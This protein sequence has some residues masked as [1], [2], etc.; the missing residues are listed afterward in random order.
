MERYEIFR[1]TNKENIQHPEIL[2]LLEEKDLVEHQLYFD[3]SIGDLLLYVYDNQEKQIVGY[4]SLDLFKEPLTAL[5]IAKIE[6]FDE[7]VYG[8]NNR[9]KGVASMLLNYITDYARNND[10]E[11]IQLAAINKR[12]ENLYYQHGFVTYGKHDL[13]WAKME[14]ESNPTFWRLSC[15]LFE[16]MREARQNNTNVKT[17]VN[18]ILKNR[19]YDR[20]FEYNV[21]EENPFDE[22]YDPHLTFFKFD[23]LMREDCEKFIH[24]GVHERVFKTLDN[25]IK[26]SDQDFKY[27]IHKLAITTSTEHSVTVPYETLF[28]DRICR[29]VVNLFIDDSLNSKDTIEETSLRKD[30]ITNTTK[31]SKINNDT[32]S[33]KSYEALNM[34]LPK[35]QALSEKGHNND[36]TKGK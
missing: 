36:F 5:Y 11:C 27:K 12:A 29:N 31:T 14:K 4:A 16:G 34:F 2:K 33:N 20:L 3:I 32:K 26:G 35:E 30:E 10:Y 13:G 24:S 19:E 22:N 18:K 9:N 23:K 15:L 6:T 25:V 21:I 7:S 1:A 28:Y 8:V 17:Q